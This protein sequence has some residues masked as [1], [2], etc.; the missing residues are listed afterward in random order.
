MEN[1]L[2]ILKIW[3]TQPIVLIIMITFLFWILIITLLF[4]FLK[5]YVTTHIN[6]LNSLSNATTKQLSS[7]ISKSQRYGLINNIKFMKKFFQKI[8]LII[9][10]GVLFGG[11]TILCLR[12]QDNGKKITIQTQQ[13]TLDSLANVIRF[14]DN[15]PKTFTNDSLL[16]SIKQNNIDCQELIKTQLLIMKNLDRRIRI[17]EDYEY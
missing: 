6:Y 16:I 2:Q 11:I 4:W 1:L 9:T 13:K 5:N 14:K 17:L 12:Y 15:Q 7:E 8:L 3:F 10:I